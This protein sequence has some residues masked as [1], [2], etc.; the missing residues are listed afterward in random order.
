MHP[1]RLA[2]DATPLLGPRA[3]IGVFTAA[4]V[5][6][7]ATRPDLAVTAYG[8]SWRGR[9]QLAGALGVG[10]TTTRRPMAA[11]PLRAVW[12]RL[13]APPIDWWTGPADVVHGTNY[14]TPPARR[15]VELASVHDLTVLHHPELC[16]ADTLAYPALVRRALRRGAHIHADSAFVAAEIREAF[17]LGEDRVHVVPL[18]VSDLGPG[19]VEVARAL[20]SPDG[21]APDATE[22]PRYVLALG[23]AEPRKDLPGLVAAFDA[24]AAHDPDL[25]LVL[26]GGDGWGTE[27]LTQAIRTATHRGRIR[28][29]A[30]H[31]SDVERSALLRSAAVLA[32]PSRYEGFG[33][34]P[35]EAMSVGTPVVATRAGSLPEVLGD[36]AHLCAAGDRDGLAAALTAVLDDGGHRAD[37]AARGRARA[38]TFSW[39]RCVDELCSLYHRLHGA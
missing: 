33:L 17:D 29:L 15:G 7:L 30:R 22:L 24:V 12:S 1:L 4:L 26:A 13:D 14:V 34:P 21:N 27:Q 10:V 8:A 36:A 25:W 9:G 37:L 39:D 6:R 19:P 32:Y 38:A 11:R 31:V 3:G 16:T 28:R 23:T 5:D 35:L 18:G 2:L 20:V